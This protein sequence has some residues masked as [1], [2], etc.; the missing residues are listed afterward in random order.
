[1]SLVGDVF[2]DSE[3]VGERGWDVKLLLLISL[4]EDFPL[5]FMTAASEY[6]GTS[7]VGTLVL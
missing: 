5:R 3:V 2:G 4:G 1:M 6:R 7:I